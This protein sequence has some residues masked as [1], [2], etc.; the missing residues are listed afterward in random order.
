MFL[1]GENQPRA[2]DFRPEVHDSD[3]LMMRRPATASGCGARCTT[4]RSRWSR[5]F[6]HRRASRGFGLMQ[7]DR[8][9]ASYEDVEAALRAPPERLGRAARRL[10]RRAASS[11]C[12]CRRPTKPTTT[13]PPTGCRQTLPAAGRAAGVRLR[14]IAL[15]GR[16]AAA[17]AATAG[18]TQSRRGVGWTRAGA[19]RDAGTQ[20]QYVVDFAGPALERAAGRRRRCEA[21]ASADANGRVLERQ[22]YRNPATGGWRMTLRVQRASTAARPVE[23]RAFLQT[24]QRHR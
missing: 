2:G 14:S 1:F 7:R 13:S 5:S 17:P 22:A 15:A 16:R 23:L 19:R 21:I 8:A 11:C 12:S 4:R 24:R 10:G 3:G 6:A 20:V 18:R 9:F